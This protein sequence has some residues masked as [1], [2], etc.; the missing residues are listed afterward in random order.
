MVTDLPG[1]GHRSSGEWSPIFR[2]MAADLPGINIVRKLMQ[3]NV[4]FA[5]FNITTSAIILKPTTTRG[6]L[7]QTLAQ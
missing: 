2:G 4:F 5:L 6:W 7:L 3:A 1:N